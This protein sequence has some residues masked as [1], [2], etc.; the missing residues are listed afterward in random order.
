M[1]FSKK[2]TSEI[3][4]QWYVFSYEICMI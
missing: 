1:F 4:G 3:L 2:N